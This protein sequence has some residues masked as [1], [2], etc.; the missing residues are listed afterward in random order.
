MPCIVS[1]MKSILSTAIATLKSVN[2]T[3]E[4]T[5]QSHESS[6]YFVCFIIQVLESIAEAGAIDKPGIVNDVSNALHRIDVPRRARLMS[7]DKLH[8]TR[9]KSSGYC[10]M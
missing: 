8:V 10:P 5:G 6:T 9:L 2:L 1:R 4:L 7:V 3:L